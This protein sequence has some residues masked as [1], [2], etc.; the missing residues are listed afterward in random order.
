MLIENSVTRVTELCDAKQLPESR[1]F[2][3]ALKNHY[4]FFFLHT[5]PSTVAFRLE[6]V[7]LYLFYATITTFFDQ[8]KFGTAPILYVDFER[9]GGNWRENDVKNE[10]KIVIL[11]SCTR[12]V[13]HPSCKTT[14]PSPGRDHGSP[15]RICKK[16]SSSPL[17]LQL[18]IMVTFAGT[19]VACPIITTSGINFSTW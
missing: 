7:L 9:F 19:A 10:V 3:F 1:N 8:E 13:L 16:I 14:F 4:G 5:L 11:T 15:G 12:V 6:Y 2:K 18:F 17:H